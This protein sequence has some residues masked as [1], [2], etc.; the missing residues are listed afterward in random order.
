MAMVIGFSIDDLLPV[1]QPLTIFCQFSTKHHFI[2][3]YGNADFNFVAT[4]LATSLKTGC[5][6]PSSA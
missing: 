5:G 4:A 2:K 1:S 3:T 6:P